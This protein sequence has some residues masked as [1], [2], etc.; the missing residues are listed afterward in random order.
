MLLTRMMEE[1]AMTRTR[2]MMGLTNSP[3]GPL[4]SIKGRAMNSPDHIGHL[5]HLGKSEVKDLPHQINHP[6]PQIEARKNS[7]PQDTIWNR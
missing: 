7:V 5:P 3:I 4:T 6:Y 1:T 2:T